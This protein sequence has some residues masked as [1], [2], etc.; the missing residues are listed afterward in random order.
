MYHNI[1]KLVTL[2]SQIRFNKSTKVEKSRVQVHSDVCIGNWYTRAC[3]AHNN[4]YSFI[5][6]QQ[7]LA[8]VP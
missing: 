4:N 3:A 1:I 5:T 2:L 7:T 6:Q 8:L